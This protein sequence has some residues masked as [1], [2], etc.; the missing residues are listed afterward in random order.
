M[1][2]DLFYPVAVAAAGELGTGLLGLDRGRYQAMRVTDV[3]QRLGLSLASASRLL[4][5]LV[6]SGYASRTT[7]RQFTVGPRSMPLAEAWAATLR[8]ASAEPVARAS[9]ATGESVMLGQLLGGEL[10]QVTW[11]PPPVRAQEMASRLAEFGTSFPAWATAAG[12]AALGKLPSAQRSRLLPPGPYPRLTDRTVTDGTEL[13]RRIRDGE[14]A[15]VHIDNGEAAYGIWCCAVAL[16]QGPMGEV[17]ALTVLSF[18]EPDG[19]CR[20]RII[21]ALRREIRDV[22]YALAASQ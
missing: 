2:F 18:G 15:G 14:R 11:A 6:E 22:G 21:S 13:R 20:Q 17:L 16:E 12:R 19:E 9:L 7:D 4:A 8:G 1:R 10:V 5:T 3:A